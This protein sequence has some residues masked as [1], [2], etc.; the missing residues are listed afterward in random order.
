[1]TCLHTGCSIYIADYGVMA[2]GDAHAYPVEGDGTAVAY[3]FR[4]SHWSYDVADWIRVVNYSTKNLLDWWDKDR[5]GVTSTLLVDGE[6]V[7]SH[8]YGRDGLTIEEHRDW[9]KNTPTT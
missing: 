1:M 3:L 4:I 5:P 8:G 6:N 7:T 2:Y 9:L